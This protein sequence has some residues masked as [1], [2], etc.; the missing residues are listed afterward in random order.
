[1][2]LTHYVRQSR[3][4]ECVEKLLLAGEPVVGRVCGRV[5]QAVHVD[6]PPG[7][8]ELADSEVRALVA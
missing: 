1:M 6:H 4:V 8:P 3:L 2:D 7:A 5:V